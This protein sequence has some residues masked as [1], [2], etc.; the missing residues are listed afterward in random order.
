MDWPAARFEA[1]TGLGIEV[2]EAQ[3]AEARARL[4]LAEAIVRYNLAQ[5]ELAASIGHLT[6]ELLSGFE[7]DAAP[8]PS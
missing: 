3:N 1:G 8:P 4:E 7:D 5:I 6:P 2:I